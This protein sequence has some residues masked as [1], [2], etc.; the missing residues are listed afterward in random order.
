MLALHLAAAE[1]AKGYAPAQV[2]NALKGIGTLEGS[3]RLVEV[4]GAHLT[5]YRIP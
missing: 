4:G 2:L 3:Q 1:A 5:R